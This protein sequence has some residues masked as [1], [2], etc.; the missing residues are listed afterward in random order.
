MPVKPDEKI[1][2]L[3][4]RKEI[5]QHPALKTYFEAYHE[6][7]QDD[8]RKSFAAMCER[9]DRLFESDVYDKHRTELGLEPIGRPRATGRV[10]AAAGADERTPRPANDGICK[11]WRNSA[12]CRKFYETHDCLWAHPEHAKG[13]D[14]WTTV[15]HKKKGKGKGKG[16]GKEKGSGKVRGY[17]AHGR[18]LATR[19]PSQRFRISQ[20][21]EDLLDSRHAA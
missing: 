3:H 15:S 8:P 6:L 7:A 19:W 17:E 14:L 13:S 16:K 10:T 21:V 9:L 11:E 2:E 5:Q 4:F 18:S 12:Y 20:E 1:L